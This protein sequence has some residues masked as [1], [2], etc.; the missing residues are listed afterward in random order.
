MKCYCH[1][2]P[3]FLVTKLFPRI[4][5][6]ATPDDGEY[7]WIPSATSG[8]F[9]G[10]NFGTYGLRIQ[11][12][13]VDNPTI[14][15]RSTETFTVPEEG[16]SYY[17]DD[18]DNTNDEYTPLAVGSNRHTGKISTMMKTVLAW[19]WRVTFS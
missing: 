12:S 17:V 6:Q 2:P 4:F 18:G 11:V 9:K 3:A 13:L 10:V 14:L 7:V 19:W 15:D 8:D 1:C 5:T 16:N